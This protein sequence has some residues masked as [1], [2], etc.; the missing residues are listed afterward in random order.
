[1]L[2]GIKSIFNSQLYAMSLYARQ[3]AGTAV[4][5]L[6][7]RFLSVHDYGLFRSY[8]TIAGFCLM[9]AN[10]EYGNYILVSSN[11]K[12]KEVKLK[13]SLFMLH[14]IVLVC[15]ALI[16]S[17]LLKIDSYLIF[18]LVLFRTFFDATFF[19][20]MLPYF[21]AS[22]KFNVISW[23]NIF[24]S[25]ATI[26]FAFICY[27]KH[28]SLV[29]FLLMGI[30]LGI[31]NFLQCSYFAN[32]NYLLLF[33]YLKKMIKKIDRS[34]FEYIFSSLTWFLYA[35]IPPLYVSTKL[36]KE[37]AAL[38][39]AAFTISN[40]VYILVNAQNQKIVPELIHSS[41]EKSKTILRKNIIFIFSILFSMLFIFILA[42]KFI[43]S[44]I[45]GK[46]IYGDA[47]ICLIILTLGNMFV[48][49]GAIHGAYIT[50]KG[51]QKY[52][53]RMML[54]ASLITILSLIILHKFGIY[55]AALSFLLAA[56]YAGTRFMLF[57]KKLLEQQKIK[58]V[59]NG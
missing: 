1:M 35:Q 10:L 27:I 37:D 33:K 15:L 23:I 36:Q 21:Q 16:T 43:L 40:I 8:G 55:S 14:A 30:C 48:A 2:K 13:I 32:I 47:N 29:T 53:S 56:I 49:L 39:F 50:A 41:Y 12:V 20:L 57:T 31:L 26:L 58:E 59:I 11:A 6:V 42:G 7:T 24:Y 51:K 17:Y 45:Y 44:L 25:L 19:G 52:K 28:Y 4:L 38:F 34:I 22:K 9:F 46:G 54:E 18:A 3:I 5:L